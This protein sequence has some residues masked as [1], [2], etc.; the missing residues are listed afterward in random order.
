MRKIYSLVLMAAALLVG[1][2]AWANY[3]SSWLQDQFDDVPADGQTHTITMQDNIVLTDPVYLG[4]ASVDDPR[5]SII[6]DMNG[7]HITMDATTWVNTKGYVFCSMFTITHGE[8]LIRNNNKSVTSTISMT[9][10]GYDYIGSDSKRNLAQ[11]NN[12]FNVAGSYKSSRWVKSVNTYEI[13]E[14]AAI[15]TRDKGWFTHLEIGEGVK[16]VAENTIYGAGISIDG[17]YTNYHAMISPNA[18]PASGNPT[19]VFGTSGLTG[20]TKNNVCLYNRSDAPAY[21]TAILSKASEGVAYGVRVDVYGDIEFAT[22]ATEGKAYGIK[23]NGGLRSSL[24]ENEIFQNQYCWYMDEAYART[25][26]ATAAPTT[27]ATKSF[28]I[29][30]TAYNNHYNDTVDAPFLYIHSTAHIIAAAEL[31]EA[32]AVYCSGYG[33]TLIEGACSGNSGINIKAGTVELH[34]AEITG[35]ATNYENAQQGNHATGS[36]GIVVNS[37]D[38]R[39]G[40]IEVVISGDTKVSTTVGYAIEE[41]V[42]KT[43]GENTDVSSIDIQGGTIEGGNLGAIALTTEGADAT[44]VTGGNSTGSVKVNNQDVNVSDLVP[45]NQDYHTT[46]VTVDGKTTIV[47]SEG[48][49]PTSKETRGTWSGLVG[50]ADSVATKVKSDSIVNAKWTGTGDPADANFTTSDGYGLI[51]SG[52]VKLGE[53]QMLAGTSATAQQVLTI[54]NGATLDVRH[55]M[56]NKYAQIIVEAGGKLIVEGTQGIVAPETRNI[57]L[58]ST[59]DDYAQFL[60]NPAVSSNRHP[61]ATIELISDSYR[62]SLEDQHNEHFGVPTSTKLTEISTDRTDHRVVFWKYD[63]ST[64]GWQKL[65]YLYPED[66]SQTALNQDDLQEPF[67]FFQMLCTSTTPGTKV[68]MKGDLVGNINHDISYISNSFMGFANSYTADIDLRTI[69]PTVPGSNKAVYVYVKEENEY[70]WVANSSLDITT[71]K[72]APMQAFVLLNRGAAASSVIK[73]D[74]MVWNP[75]MNPSPAPAR[76]QNYDARVKIRISTLGA[77]DYVTLIQDNSFTA[78][79]DMGEAEKYMNEKL[80]IYVTDDT[81]KSIFASDDMDNTYLGLNC[82]N[83]GVCTLTFTEVAGDNLVLVDLL[84]NAVVPMTTGMTYQFDAVANEDSDY[85]FQIRKIANVVTNGESINAETVKNEGIY[86]ITGQYLGNMSIW[87]TLPSG[88][89]IVDGVKKVK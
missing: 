41:V 21:N 57:V 71:N 40:G 3:S 44:Q 28:L 10:K 8:L 70:H 79:F 46:T 9:G 30:E 64:S 47:V 87:N 61:N 32:T 2:N 63:Y 18:V 33:K 48:A 82:K 5:K 27:N 85:R 51:A 62:M 58:K 66:P 53:L 86:S 6:L 80:N 39:A 73:Y 59:N 42:N 54:N 25:Y 72:I 83:A 88:L 60:F 13:D 26:G 35:T 84:T 74:D 55:L 14:D 69:L 24:R 12:I 11:Y 45:Q 89:Y 29:G 49:A 77:V 38:N 15:N 19:G 22:A 17:Y 76:E 16:V 65:G 81:Q 4:T 56:M 20:A 67:S 34:D 1:T 36:G 78:D 68:T 7:H 37:V 31:N 50:Y 43:N 75:V 52:T 23:L